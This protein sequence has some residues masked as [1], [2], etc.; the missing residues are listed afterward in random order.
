MKRS[1]LLIPLALLVILNAC[2]QPDS[3]QIPPAYWDYMA[4]TL[5][6]TAA[7]PTATATPTRTPN[8]L[9]IMNWLNA[10]PSSTDPFSNYLDQL[11]DTIG[12]NYKFLDVQFP[13]DEQGMVTVFE[14]DIRCQCARNDRCCSRERGFILTMSRM[15]PY[16]DG[17]V[18][19]VPTTVEQLRVVTYDHVN[20][21]PSVSADWQ[22]VQNFL[23]GQ[24]DG[25]QFG[26]H[27]T[28]ASH[29]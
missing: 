1:Y 24:M 18:Y 27:V 6:A 5:T 11:E 29:P 19:E 28:P 21:F 22:D 13:L 9:Q 8:E 17:I 12:V 2:G 23:H 16:I 3:G 25:N 10:Q 26:F 4:Q 20:P 15:K 7:P 14:V